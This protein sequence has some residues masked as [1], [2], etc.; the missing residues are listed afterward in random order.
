MRTAQVGED[1][2]LAGGAAAVNDDAAVKGVLADLAAD[3]EVLGLINPGQSPQFEVGGVS[4]REL[5][6]ARPA[7]LKKGSV[8]P[9]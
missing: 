7:G 6:Q 8:G 9:G 5:L 4:E 2:R 3:L 1:S